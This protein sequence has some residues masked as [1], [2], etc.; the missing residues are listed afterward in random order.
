R[1]SLL[2]IGV[3]KLVFDCG[4]AAVDHE[5]VH[6]SHPVGRKCGQMAP[7]KGNPIEKR[8]KNGPGGT[9]KLWKSIIIT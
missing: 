2:I 9:R 5:Y 8:L 7:P 1:K 6:S 3:D 4:T